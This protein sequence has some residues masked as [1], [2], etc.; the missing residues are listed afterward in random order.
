VIQGADGEARPVFKQTSA[1]NIW[2]VNGSYF[3]VKGIEFT[4]GGRGIRL[5]EISN[6]S[7][8]TFDSIYIHDVADNGFSA[9]DYNKV[10]ESITLRNSEITK[11]GHTGECVY[12]GCQDNHC[13]TFNSLVENNYCHDTTTDGSGSRGSGFQI[14]TGSYNNVVRN[15]V[16]YN[17]PGVCVLMYDDYNLGANLIEGNV[18][19][20]VQSDNGIQV[21]A[22]A[23]VRN[24]IVIGFAS[25]G[26]GVLNNQAMPNSSPRNLVI[27]HNTVYN[28]KGT[29]LVLTSVSSDETW[30]VSN[31]AFYCGASAAVSIASGSLTGTVFTN[32]A[33]RGS[34]PTLPASNIQLSATIAQVFANIAN[35]NVYPAVGSA[36]IKAGDSTHSTTIDFNGLPRGNPPTIGAYEF[37]A[38]TN[39]GW[40]VQGAFKK[41]APGASPPPPIVSPPPPNAGSSP[42]PAGSAPTSGSAS[43]TAGTTSPSTTNPSGVTPTAQFNT[44]V[45]SNTPTASSI[46]SSSNTR[47]ISGA[48]VL[49]VLSAVLLA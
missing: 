49:L 35:N 2:D 23:I 10:Y 15:N 22:G 34:V 43:P 11:T 17:T 42:S 26:I 29:C 32:N 33:Y 47:S 4:G 19:L 25:Y 6:T 41:L 24:N 31:N 12:L 9:N 1:Q 7:H 18:A 45:Q 39:P 38:D 27:E 14:K 37:S 21:T 44:P 8:V 48:A 16:C 3:T 5:G 20:N 28:T 40:A 30:V 36:L 46:T 13:R